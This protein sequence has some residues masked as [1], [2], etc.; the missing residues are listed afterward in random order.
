ME[1]NSIDD[2]LGGVEPEV[3]TPEVAEEPD[4]K[5]E[6]LRG[7][8]GKFAKKEE[9]GV[10][11]PEVQPEAVPVPPTEPT[12]QLPREE[13]SVLRA[14]RD[15]NKELK[16][17]IAEIQRQMSQPQQPQVEY[18]FWENP[19]QYLQSQFSQFGE[20]LFNQFEQRQQAQRIDASE[21]AAR[22]KYG[23]FDEALIAFENAVQANPRLAVEMAQAPDPAEY[24]YSK[25]KTALAIN[26]VGSIDQLK[27]Q[28][29]AELE[30]ELKATVPG[31]KPILPSTTAADGSVAG[32]GSPQWAGP[33]SIN[34][35]LG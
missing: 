31:V 35:I 28:I 4:A 13:Y 20:K 10:S 26:T 1:G 29:R 14:V 2:I 25:G 12:N 5:P 9:T 17:Q 15:E 24:A 27:A 30:A 11:E 22:A 34:D 7:P 6:P 3:V 33:T 8:D 18:D 19:Q 16:R 32:R 21:A 23:D